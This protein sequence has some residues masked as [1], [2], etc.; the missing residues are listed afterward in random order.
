MI[1]HSH[2]NALMCL[3]FSS[4][5]KDV[6]SNWF[7]SP[8]PHSLRNFEEGTEVFLN[9]YASCREA[10]KNHRLISVKIKHDDSLKSYIGYFQSQLV[11]VLN[12]DEDASALAFINGLQTLTP[13]TSTC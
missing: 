5:L 8:P 10:K 11:K 13:C 9:Q 6:T 1:I 12:C 4:S 2:N 7:Y 3:T